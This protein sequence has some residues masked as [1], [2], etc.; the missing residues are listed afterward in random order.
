VNL[1]EVEAAA[2]QTGLAREC[3]AM[4]LPDEDWGERLTLFCVASGLAAEELKRALSKKLSGARLPKEV[5]LVDALPLNEMGKPD[6][7]AALRLVSGTG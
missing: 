1:E 3:L 2:R 5:L 4:G 7:A 6:F